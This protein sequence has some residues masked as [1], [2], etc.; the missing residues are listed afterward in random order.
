MASHHHLQTSDITLSI[1]REMDDNLFK[2]L[3]SSNGH[4][5]TFMASESNRHAKRKHLHTAA[6]F[7]TSN[8]N[9]WNGEISAGHAWNQLLF[10]RDG[11]LGEVYYGIAL[12]D[13]HIWASAV[14]VVDGL[15]VS[16][17]P[18]E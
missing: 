2:W 8:P 10:L 9:D 15:K 14:G 13:I 4:T 16:D 3:S 6:T 18:I 12:W 5:L 11:A 17:R 7:V 1:G